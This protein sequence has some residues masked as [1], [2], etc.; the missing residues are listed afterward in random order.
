MHPNPILR[1]IALLTS[2]PFL[3]AVAGAAGVRSGRPVAAPP[4]RICADPNNLPFSNERLDGFENRLATL[5]ARDFATTVE[6]TWWAQ[7]RGF[8]RET[9]NAGRCDVVL[10]MPS[11]AA[12]VATTRPYYRSSYVFVTRAARGLRISS[13]DDPALRHLRVGVQIIG[14]DGAN[15][16]PAHALSRRGIV[17]NLV[18]Y[19]VLGDYSRDSPPSEIVAAVA[20]GDVDI[21]AAWGP[22]AGYFSALQP[23]PLVV[24]PI[25]PD[26]DGAL[27]QAFD[28]SMA[29][30]RDDVDR[31]ALLNRFI[32]SHTRQ[33]DELLAAYRVPRAVSPVKASR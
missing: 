2:I 16:P 30:R 9:L 21:A 18:G 1:N 19:S 6:Y 32:E 26:V 25:Q 5:I 20:R 28:I 31:L 33:I 14:D 10:G 12:G 24:V 27:P 4:L 22:M 17:S 11:R 7:R 29:V 3:V 15:S 13:F 8:L 23:E